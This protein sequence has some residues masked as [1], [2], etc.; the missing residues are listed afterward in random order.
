[1]GNYKQDEWEDLGRE[2][3]IN[4]KAE[5]A[6]VALI[7][8]LKKTQSNRRAGSVERGVSGLETTSKQRISR[9]VH[10]CNW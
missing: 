4:A 6:R 8:G 5:T 2:G 1:M 7:L 10:N 3:Q 9:V